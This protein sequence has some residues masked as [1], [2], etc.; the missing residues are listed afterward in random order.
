[1]NAE[2]GGETAYDI[3]AENLK[4]FAEQLILMLRIRSIP[5]G[6]KLFENVDEMKTI[7]GLRTPTSDFRFTMC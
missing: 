6:M 5:I 7:P 2:L 1:M 3:N 4:T